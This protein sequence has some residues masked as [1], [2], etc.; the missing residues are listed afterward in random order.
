MSLRLISCRMPST[1]QVLGW[2]EGGAEGLARDGRGS[3]TW[4][5]CA[6]DAVTGDCRL[7]LL[8]LCRAEDL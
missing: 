7:A 1:R 2:L 3:N 4:L 6:Q 8:T 5:P